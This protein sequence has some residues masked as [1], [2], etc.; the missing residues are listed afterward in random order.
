MSRLARQGLIPGWAQYSSVWM[1]I[2]LTPFLISCTHRT[3]DDALPEPAGTGCPSLDGSYTLQSS[4]GFGLN[5][6]QNIAPPDAGNDWIALTLDSIASGSPI[7]LRL[8]RSDA[9][10]AQ[11]T[12]SFRR[13]HPDAWSAWR[14]RASLDPRLL[15]SPRRHIEQ[16]ARLGP[17]PEFIAELSGGQCDQGWLRFSNTE[18][19]LPGAVAQDDRR[20]QS[21]AFAVASDG[22]LI[23][24]EQRTLQNEFPIWCGD[25]CKG[26]P[27][28]FEIED[29][30]ARFPRIDA[31]PVWRLGRSTG[32][33]TPARPTSPS[34]RPDSDPRIAELRERVLRWLPKDAT[35]FNF[36]DRS[37][38]IVFSG[39]CRTK[40]DLEQLVFLLEGDALVA[41]SHAGANTRTTGA[42]SNSGWNCASHW[43]TDPSMHQH[44]K[45]VATI[46]A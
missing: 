24:H 43:T 38:T 26:I 37:G 41:K 25:G 30:W 46:A 10:M 8:R 12:E 5:L 22:A 18:R 45:A 17:A 44:D 40:A 20:N 23:V 11:R 42:T 19:S 3:G 31:P 7:H 6:A 39:T 4:G 13:D 21:L 28:S 15:D 14:E 34:G 35:L 33:T 1:L 27:Y 29:R 36:Y 32:N 16:L 9:D 2:I